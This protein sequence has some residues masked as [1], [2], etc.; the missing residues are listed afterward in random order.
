MAV[1]FHGQV[2]I[3]L[4]ELPVAVLALFVFSA[5]FA[6]DRRAAPLMKS[7]LLRF[8]GAARRNQVP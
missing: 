2:R 7:V 3:L 1:A 5:W 8:N 4:R 6:W